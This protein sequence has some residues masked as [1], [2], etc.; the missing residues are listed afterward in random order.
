MKRR[1]I[2]QKSEADG[3]SSEVGSELLRRRRAVVFQTE[4]VMNGMQNRKFAARPC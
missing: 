1:Y 3:V 4:G 2:Q